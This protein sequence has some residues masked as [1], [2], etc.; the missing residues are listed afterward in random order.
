MNVVDLDLFQALRAFTILS[1][2]FTLLSAAL[3]TVRLYRQQRR[4]AIS[5]R[6]DCGRR[7]R[8]LSAVWYAGWAMAL[9]KF[10]LHKLTIPRSV[11]SSYVNFYGYRWHA[12]ASLIP[13]NTAFALLVI[14]IPLHLITTL[15]Y[16]RAINGTNGGVSGLVAA[17]PPALLEQHQQQ[18]ACS[19]GQLA[20]H[21][22]L[23]EQ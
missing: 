2:L 21:G 13:V 12:G 15:L 1:I 10:T 14:A 23:G 9:G 4:R 19:E 18:Q 3:S 5:E 20:L 16:K 11:I 22:G 17:A 7:T 6:L 8:W